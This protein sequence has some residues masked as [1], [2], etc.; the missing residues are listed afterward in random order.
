ML[1]GTRVVY[2]VNSLL[3]KNDKWHLGNLFCYLFVGMNLL[4]TC[5]SCN[6]RQNLFQLSYVK[7]YSFDVLQFSTAYQTNTFLLGKDTEEI[8][9]FARVVYEKLGIQQP[10]ILTGNIYLF[11]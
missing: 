10:L 11:I 7:F 4:L 1:S 9:L 6:L 3:G 2:S 8:H 5:L